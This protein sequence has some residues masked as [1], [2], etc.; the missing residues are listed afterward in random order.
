LT[1]SKDPVVFDLLNPVLQM[2][3]NKVWQRKFG[4]G[5]GKAI[6]S[7]NPDDIISVRV[8]VSPMEG[9]HDA[10]PDFDSFFE[11]TL[12]I[13]TGDLKVPKFRWRSNFVA[14]QIETKYDIPI[15][16]KDSFDEGFSDQ[17]SQIA[18]L[19]SEVDALFKAAVQLLDPTGFS[20]M[21]YGERDLPGLFVVGVDGMTDSDQ[22]SNGYH[23]Y[24][25]V[26]SESKKTDLCDLIDG[27]A[28]KW[29]LNLWPIHRY[30]RAIPDIHADF[31]NVLDLLFAIEGVFPKNA[32]TD[33][34]KLT[35]ALCM[36]K[37]KQDIAR[38]VIQRLGV[39]Y[40]IRNNIVHGS[41]ATDAHDKVVVEGKKVSAQ[42][43]FFDVRQI[44]AMLIR[45]AVRK[46]DD[47]KTGLES[48]RLT[49]DDV[50]ERVYG[51]DWKF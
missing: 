17:F 20:L 37:T 16:A 42:H 18:A 45:L 23:T 29:H 4:Y 14:I 27:L 39:A 26:C 3:K 51:G 1:E 49:M 7:I 33:L 5:Y 30:L 19:I 36:A 28:S 50:I 47:S 8:V 34:V 22:I 11:N 10:T 21:G 13:E 12:A 46:I 15:P 24:P 25:G 38:G 44:A 2:F 31:E 35:S 43:L 41:I 48:L 32:T 6:E 40:K 9:W